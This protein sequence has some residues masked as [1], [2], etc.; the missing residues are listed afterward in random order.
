VAEQNGYFWTCGYW[1]SR[2]IS[3]AY[4]SQI[5]Q[6]AA[7]PEKVYLQS[8]ADMRAA[9]GSYLQQRYG[10]SIG[11]GGYCDGLLSEYEADAYRE[12][13]KKFYRDQEKGKNIIQTDWM[14]AELKKK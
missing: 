4:Y 14:P 12:S 6:V 7:D 10:V 13:S 3:T 9:W 2:A 8:A 1:T 5:G 11:K